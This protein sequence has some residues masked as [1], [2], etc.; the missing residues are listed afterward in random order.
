[1]VAEIK[2]SENQKTKKNV[3]EQKKDFFPSDIQKIW[4]VQNNYENNNISSNN[5]N[6][7]KLAPYGTGGRLLKSPNTANFKVT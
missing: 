2:S 4:N 6:N 7:K 3:R 5:K 1:L